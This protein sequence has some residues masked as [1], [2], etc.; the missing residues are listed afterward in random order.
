MRK[1]LLFLIIFIIFVIFSYGVGLN[2]YY[3]KKVWES[4]R[5]FKIPESVW[6]DKTTN[7]LYVSNINREKSN[8][9]YNGFISK[10]SIDGEIIKLKWAKG[11]KD[12]KGICTYKNNLYV[13]DVDTIVKI[14][15]KKGKILKRYRVEG[16]K[17]LNDII[18]DSKGG[19]YFSDTSREN[20][21]IY[22]LYNGNIEKWLEGEKISRPN[23]LFY[24]K[25]VL[26]VGNSGDKKIKMFDVNSKKYLGE[27][28][29]GT[30]IDGLV[31]LKKGRFLTSDWA[32]KTIFVYKTGFKKILLD[33]AEERINAAD[34][35]F[36][37]QRNLIVIPTFFDNRIIAY[38][39]IK[40]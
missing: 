36:V 8:K 16:A 22:K 39:L 30:G 25:D 19:I 1:V 35:G 13:T 21:V 40:R 32:G 15:L 18:A 9:P 31:Y 20:S 17:F 7:M 28:F 11:L 12:P 23:G 14:D 3:V 29:V 37:E 4:E 2:S 27:I 10:V 6:Y 5:V 26:Y 33:T 34:I 24:Y 38:K